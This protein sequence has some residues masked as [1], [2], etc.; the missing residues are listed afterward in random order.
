MILS[1][2]IICPKCRVHLL[3]FVSQ[4]YRSPCFKLWK[5]RITIRLLEMYYIFAFWHRPALQYCSI[6]N[7]IN[8]LVLMSEMTIL[9]SES[10]EIT[11]RLL[12][13]SWGSHCFRVIYFSA[14]KVKLLKILKF[15]FS[16][17]NWLYFYGSIIFFTY[18]KLSMPIYILKNLGCK[19]VRLT[20][21]QYPMI[22]TTSECWKLLWC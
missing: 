3:N 17:W 9:C 7:T 19:T 5:L 6:H 21:A 22:S 18:I 12:A 20:E 4:I 8:L 14:L 1:F 2:R 13:C 15:L 11:L 10:T 16:W